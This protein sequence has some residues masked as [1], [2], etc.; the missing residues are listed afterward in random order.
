MGAD[1]R[2][3]NDAEADRL[4]TRLYREPYVVPDTV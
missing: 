3:A 2:F 4:L 1:E